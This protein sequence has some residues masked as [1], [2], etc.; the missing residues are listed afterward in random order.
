[1]VIRQAMLRETTIICFQCLFQGGAQW[2]SARLRR[3]W[4][5]DALWLLHLFVYKETSN[6]RGT[7]KDCRK[8]G[9]GRLRRG[10]EKT[11]TDISDFNF[12][13]L[14]LSKRSFEP[15]LVDWG[16]W[17]VNFIKDKHKWCKNSETM[18]FVFT[19]KPSKVSCLFRVALRLQFTLRNIR[20]LRYIIIHCSPTGCG[21]GI[22]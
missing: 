19:Q 2:R 10:N 12:W 14:K 8:K 5:D 22:Y 21:G 18:I 15:R 3:E 11:V 9:V 17:Q 4:V 16:R 20:S 1:M 7:Y 6:K 13:V